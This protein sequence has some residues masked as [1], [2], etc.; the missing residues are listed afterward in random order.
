MS[1]SIDTLVEDIY[2][3]FDGNPFSEEAIRRFGDSLG[4]HLSSRITDQRG[5]PSLRVS[6]LG[7]VCDRKLWYGINQ[8]G[9]GEELSGPTRFKFLYGDLLEELVLFLA[10]QSG[11][12]VEACQHEV[13]ILGVKGHID[14][15]VDGRLVDVKSASTYGYRKFRENN[16][17]QDDPFGYLTQLGAYAYGLRNDPRITERDVVSFIAIDKTLGHICLDTYPVPDIDYE[18][19]VRERQAMLSVP[20]PP[21]RGY[22]DEVDGKSGNRKLGVACSY[23]SFKSVCWPGLRTFVYSNGPTFLTEVAREPKVPEL[24]HNQKVI[25]KF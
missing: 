8:P 1:K 15:I 12:K 7:T 19:M 6:N 10:E 20:E 21:E 25:D 3:T 5:A 17:R 9:G 22:E 13:D 24:D 23:C 14:A 18:Q 4:G 16:L 11:H 2:A